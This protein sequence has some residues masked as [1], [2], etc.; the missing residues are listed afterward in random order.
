[1]ITRRAVAVFLLCACARPVRADVPQP[2]AAPAGATPSRRGS[3]RMN[4]LSKKTLRDC[5]S[6]DAAVVLA[7]VERAQVSAPG[8]R[9]E[10][11]QVDL[12]VERTLCGSSPETV[13]AWRYTSRGNTILEEGERYVVAIA[14]GQGAV[15]WALGDFVRV[16]PGRE[17]EAVDA[18][19][20]ILRRMKPAGE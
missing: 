11:A 10:S 2:R 12:K 16:P 1:M 7:R 14:R 9:S 17:A 18:H 13:R 20:A 8:T 3:Q 4:T 15:P 5:R 19:L 6:G